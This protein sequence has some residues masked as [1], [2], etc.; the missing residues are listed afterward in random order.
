MTI[1]K[2]FLLFASMALLNA[3][4]SPP[5]KELTRLST[6]GI[7]GSYFTLGSTKD[8]VISLHG[9]PTSITSFTDSSKEWWRYFDWGTYVRF[10]GGRVVSWEITNFRNPPL[11]AFIGT[12]SNATTIA[13]GSSLDDVVAAMGI[14]TSIQVMGSELTWI[15]Y[16]KSRVEMRHGVVT[17]WDDEA[18]VLKL[19]A[20]TH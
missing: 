10:T 16:G 19:G 1:M 3:C 5:P 18:H 2:A 4:K 17:G 9:P 6:S 12:S 11:K 13:Q 15:D 7:A 14:P 20:M 8:E